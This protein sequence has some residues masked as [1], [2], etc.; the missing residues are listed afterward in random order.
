MLATKYA[1][2]LMLQE[3]GSYVS[4]HN[5]FHINV[6]VYVYA[7]ACECVTIKKMFSSWCLSLV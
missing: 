5:E 3:D 6:W 4:I 1:F 7:Y 2:E